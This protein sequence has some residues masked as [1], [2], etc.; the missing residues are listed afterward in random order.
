MRDPALSAGRSTWWDER[1][2]NWA[3][4]RSGA[5]SCGLGLAT[6]GTWGGDCTRPPQPL[7]GEAL[8]IDNLVQQLVP[9]HIEAVTAWYVWTGTVEDRAAVLGVH[10]NTLHN[11]VAAAKA[12]LDAL[13]WSRRTAAR[14]AD[15]TRETRCAKGV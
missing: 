6:D 14:L 15:R 8:D 3:L 7:V 10:R 1:L 13:W 12:C 9:E 2:E 5:D 11:R 4:W